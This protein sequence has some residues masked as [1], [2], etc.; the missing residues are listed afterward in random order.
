MKTIHKISL[1]LIGIMFSF[2]SCEDKYEIGGLLSKDELD[3]TVVQ[4]YSQDT[5]GNTVILTNLTEG[6]SAYWEYELG[7]SNKEEVTV[8]FPFAGTYTIQFTAM[9]DGGSVAADPI[10]VTVTENNLNYVSGELWENITGGGVGYSKTWYLDL[11]AEGVCKY[12]SSPVYYYGQNYTWF[13]DEFQCTDPDD[14]DTCWSWPPEYSTNTWIGDPADHGQMTFGLENGATAYVNHAQMPALGEQNGSFFIDSDN[15]TL[16]FTGAEM[17]HLAGFD[18]VVSDWSNITII[19]I[20]EDT[21]QLAAWR[22]SSTEED[23]WLVFNFISQEYSD[24]WVATDEVVEPELPDDWEDIV[25]QI[26]NTAIEW[27]LDEETPI[28][29]ANLDGSLMNDWNSAADYPD[30]LGTPD[31]SVFGDFSMITDSSDNSVIFN[32]PDGTITSGTY[33]LSSNGTY[34]FDIAVPSFSVID[35]AYFYADGNNELRIL[36]L[37]TDS[38]GNVTDMW[39]G[40]VNDIN[41]PTQYTAYHLV[42]SSSGGSGG[43]TTTGTDIPVDNTLIDYGDL[44]NNG[45]LRIEI[46]NDF[47]STSSAPPVDTSLFAFDNYVEVTFT[48][49]GTGVTGSYDTAIYYADSDWAPQGNGDTISVTGDGTYTVIYDGGAS[50]DGCI[51]FVID[52]A[53]MANDITD[54]TT[55]TANIDSITIY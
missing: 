10:T 29:W 35:W 16:S 46:Y 7:T 48:I 39:L 41:N 52:I 43:G 47:G 9:T 25:S 13:D 22:D 5:G 17:L 55:V 20:D 45:N 34:S 44:E 24:N 18:D 15:Y 32:T 23:A 1:L 21:M 6:A 51:V 27:K 14:T 3:F 12:F 42:P 2:V 54:L 38:N 40:A 37:D 50:V 36:D 33:A 28:N 19:S 31:P 4:D 53:G 11:D 30:W 8:K 26:T 49:S